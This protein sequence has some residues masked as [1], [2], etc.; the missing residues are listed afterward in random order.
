MVLKGND[1]RFK[2]NNREGTVN[3]VYE[4]PISKSNG[5]TEKNYQN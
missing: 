5:T 3:D 4:A 2:L 1:I